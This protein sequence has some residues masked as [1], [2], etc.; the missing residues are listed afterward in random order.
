MIVEWSLP[1]MVVKL[2]LPSVGILQLLCPGIHPSCSCHLRAYFSFM[3]V[4]SLPQISSWDF[5]PTSRFLSTFS[6]LPLGLVLSNLVMHM[7]RGVSTSTSRIASVKKSLESI[8]RSHYSLQISNV[9]ARVSHVATF[10]CS[11]GDI[12]SSLFTLA[13]ENRSVKKAYKD[14]AFFEF[15]F[16]KAT[17]AFKGSTMVSWMECIILRILS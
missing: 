8:H 10:W 9:L 5:R 17:G 7:K 2:L 15:C 14:R 6:F 3:L 1:Q 12:L 4:N 16:E 13:A 11:I